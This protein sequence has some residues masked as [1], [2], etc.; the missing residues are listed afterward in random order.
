MVRRSLKSRLDAG[1]ERPELRTFQR[2]DPVDVMKRE[3]GRYA[4]LALTVL[5]GYFAAGR[6]SQKQPLGGFE[7]YSRNVRDSLLWLGE[8]DPI[9]TMEEARVQ[10][11]HRQ[12]LEAVI[13]Q[14][15]QHLGS[16]SYTTGELVDYANEGNSSSSNPREIVYTH[17]D[18]RRALLAAGVDH[19]GR[20]S[21]IR[22]GR[23]LSRNKGKIVGGRR[24]GEDTM[25][26]GF[27]RWKLQSFTNGIWG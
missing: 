18:F 17:P 12:T 22:L 20:L 9:A 25:L 8:A 23:W 7:E 2:E 1:V 14:W 3:R 15:Q 21:P 10:D 26:D 27:A 11:P 24:I 6:P 19:S 16:S 4:S 13:V 5:R